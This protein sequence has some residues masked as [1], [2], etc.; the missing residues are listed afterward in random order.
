MARLRE[1]VE[2]GKANGISG[3]QMVMAE[4][5]LRLHGGS[6]HE[7]LRLPAEAR[8]AAREEEH[9]AQLLA[10]V[11]E[12]TA[13]KEALAVKRGGPCIR[14]AQPRFSDSYTNFWGKRKYRDGFGSGAACSTDVAVYRDGSRGQ[15][16]SEPIWRQAGDGT[17]HNRRGATR[18]GRTPSGRS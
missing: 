8:E 18:G 10:D 12:E 4:E 14:R 3:D 16:D 1:L 9:Q 5:S 15:A 2:R 6:L 17:P 7:S 11:E 13:A